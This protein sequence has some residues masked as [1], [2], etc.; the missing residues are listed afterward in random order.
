MFEKVKKFYELG[1]YSK[2][3]VWQFVVKGKLTEEQYREI[4]G[5]D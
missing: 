5:E 1:L 2:E 3:Q 4:V